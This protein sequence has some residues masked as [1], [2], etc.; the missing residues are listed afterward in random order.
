ML[1]YSS[2]CCR[3]R[4]PFRGLRIGSCLTLGNELSDETHA[5]KD[6]LGKGHPGREQQGKGIKEN[7]SATGLDTLGFTMG[8]LVWVASSQPF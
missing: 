3:K 1:I 4:D 7:C 6:F 2:I 8:L 5:D